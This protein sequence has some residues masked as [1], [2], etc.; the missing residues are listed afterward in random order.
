M[1]THRITHRTASYSSIIELHDVYNTVPDR[2]PYQLPYS[3]TS[4]SHCIT[5]KSPRVRVIAHSGSGVSL[6]MPHPTLL[7]EP[8]LLRRHW[9]EPHS[10][11]PETN[12][13]RPNRATTQQINQNNSIENEPRDNYTMGLPLTQRNHTTNT[14]HLHTHTCTWTMSA[15]GLLHIECTHI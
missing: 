8:K 9:S 15:A 4:G 5:L 7:S 12:L 10:N 14:M 3:H 6:G 13:S 11:L 1:P 2:M